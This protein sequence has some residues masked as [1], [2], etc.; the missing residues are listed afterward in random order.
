MASKAGAG[1]DAELEDGSQSAG[2]CAADSSFVFDSLEA[3][4]RAR[5]EAEPVPDERAPEG[6]EGDLQAV[7]DRYT[8]WLRTLKK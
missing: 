3:L 2:D 6:G 8:D 4:R 5:P 7:L 1:V